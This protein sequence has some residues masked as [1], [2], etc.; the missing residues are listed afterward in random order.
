MCFG[1]FPCVMMRPHSLHLL[2]FAVV[3]LLCYLN[4]SCRTSFFFLLH[5]SMFSFL[6]IPRDLLFFSLCFNNI[7]RLFTGSRKQASFRL[8]WAEIQTQ[9]YRFSHATSRKWGTNN[10]NRCAQLE[11]IEKIVL[12]TNI[13]LDTSHSSSITSRP[14]QPHT[15]CT[16][17]FT[18]PTCYYYSIATSC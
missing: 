1:C 5:F 2:P 3:V 16:C 7:H 8:S 17:M 6:L 9:L 15:W 4:T 12:C 10:S 14:F 18:S 13:D 11:S